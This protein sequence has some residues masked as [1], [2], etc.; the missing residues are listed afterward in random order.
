[1]T[2]HTR[3]VWFF[4]TFLAVLVR[5]SNSSQSTFDLPTEHTSAKPHIILC[6]VDDL[7]WHSVYNNDDVFTPTIDSLAKAGTKLTSF[8]TYRYL[9]TLFCTCQITR[10]LQVLLPDTSLFLGWKAAIQAA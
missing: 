10:C 9:H 6:L 2:A 5:A 8:Y 1:M 7:G 4:I 3:A